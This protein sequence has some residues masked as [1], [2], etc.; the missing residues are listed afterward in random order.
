MN[1]IHIKMEYE[2]K[3]I[4]KCLHVVKPG[5]VLNMNIININKVEYE[6]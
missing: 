3:S 5:S 4:Y 6:I 1:N 2:I